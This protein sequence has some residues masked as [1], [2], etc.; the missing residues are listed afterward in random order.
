MLDLPNVYSSPALQCV[1]ETP[2]KG[3]TKYKTSVAIAKWSLAKV[4]AWKANHATKKHLNLLHS[5][6]ADFKTILS[7]LPDPKTGI[8]PVYVEELLDRSELTLNC[9]H[10]AALQITHVTNMVT[11]CKEEVY[12]LLNQVEERLA[13]W[14]N[15]VPSPSVYNCSECPNS[16]FFCAL[17]INLYLEVTCSTQML[18]QCPPP[19]KSLFS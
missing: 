4:D 16:P 17:Q 3:A 2:L 18:T 15:T 5:I 7:D 14:R 11:Q 6:E 9:S 19:I 13:N 12:T 8:R 10:T 1:P